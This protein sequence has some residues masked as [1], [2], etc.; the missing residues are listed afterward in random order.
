VSIEGAFTNDVP[1]LYDNAASSLFRRKSIL[2]GLGTTFIFGLSL[3][4]QLVVNP[5][6]DPNMN[7]LESVGLGVAA[8]TLVSVD[9]QI[10]VVF[11]HQKYPS[12]KLNQTLSQ[13]TQ[14]IALHH[15]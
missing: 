11:P 6:S 2:P 3:V 8:I 12:I 5:F 13:F 9:L 15:K 14:M 7:Y 10:E 4:L 1:S